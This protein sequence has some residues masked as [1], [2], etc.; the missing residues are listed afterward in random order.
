M[1]IE[2]NHKAL[3]YKKEIATSANFNYIFKIQWNKYK[4]RAYK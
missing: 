2:I 1:I 3:A 4:Y